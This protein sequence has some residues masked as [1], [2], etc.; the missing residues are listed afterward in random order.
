MSESN[1]A[2]PPVAWTGTDYT[3]I[4]TVVL[5]AALEGGLLIGS[6]LAPA[7]YDTLIDGLQGL[8]RD[9]A[10]TL[11]E[12]G[13][14]LA[15][16][17]VQGD[18]LALYFYDPAEVERNWQL[19]GPTSL[20]GT[21]RQLLIN[22]CRRSNSALTFYAI[23]AAVQLKN[24]WLVHEASLGRVLTHAEPWELRSSLH[25]GWAILRDRADGARR[26]EGQTVALGAHLLQA[27]PAAAYSGVFVSQSFHDTLRASVVKHTQLRQRVM[28]H[29]CDDES[30]RLM[31]LA[32][33][34]KLYELKFCHRAGIP[35]SPDTIEQYAAV[36]NLDNANLWAYYQ[37]VE[38]YGYQRRDWNRV[39]ALAKAAQVVHPEDERIQLDLAKYYFHVGK[40][41]QSRLFAEQA[42]RSNP[43]FDLAHEHL[44]VIAHKYGDVEAQIGHWR[45]AVRLVPGSPVNNFN[46]GLAL[47]TDDRIEEGFHYIQEALRIYPEYR[48][49]DSFNEAIQRIRREGK[50]PEL[51]EGLLQEE[52]VGSS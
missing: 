52:E 25:C 34:P 28:F 39:F 16:W 49:W 37:L 3:S 11:L 26:I 12:Q 8:V 42:L 43:A 18:R 30:R 2:V 41:E 44:A 35:V 5:H 15:E 22:E 29:T 51:L 21:E 45:D 6:T 38:Y 17:H 10:A 32:R 13:Y 14:P 31:P 19:D 1:G 47:L 20:D 46:L 36:F 48:T 7:D 24:R 33:P 50:L 40:L 9:L 23:Q 4:H 27:A